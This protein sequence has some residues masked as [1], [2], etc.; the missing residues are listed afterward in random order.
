MALVLL[1]EAS[2]LVRS[3]NGT[4]IESSIPFAKTA[5]PGWIGDVPIFDEIE[6]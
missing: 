3:R 2:R 4:L 5:F 6:Q 1:E